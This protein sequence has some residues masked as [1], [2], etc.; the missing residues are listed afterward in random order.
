MTAARCSVAEDAV[1]SRI[2]AAARGWLGTPYLHQSS[3]KGAGTD[4][5]GFVR[6]VWRELHGAEPEVPPAY[7]PDW[8]EPAAEEALWR[9]AARHMA[10]VPRAAAAAGDVLLFRMRRGGPAKHLAILTDMR[11]AEPR[12]IHAYSGRGVVESS[13]GPS[14]RRR[15]AAAF[16]FPR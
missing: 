13:L 16:R 2:V 11:G 5:L 6:G 1:A 12:M 7:T 3:A 4:C 10:P 9:A 15:V 14:W 8:S